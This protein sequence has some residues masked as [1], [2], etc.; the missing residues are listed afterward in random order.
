MS[1][2]EDDPASFAGSVV[3]VL[4]TLYLDHVGFDFRVVE[5]RNT[6]LNESDTAIYGGLSDEFFLLWIAEFWKTQTNID[7][8]DT[9]P[10][11]AKKV[12]QM[13]GE[14]SDSH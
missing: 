7:R 6:H 4:V 13:T 9:S 14:Y 2:D 3:K 12:Q 5:P 8:G 11:V 10:I 1:A